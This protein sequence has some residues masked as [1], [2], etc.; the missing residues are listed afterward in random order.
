M[1]K[2]IV[3]ICPLNRIHSYGPDGSVRIIMEN[4][5]HGCVWGSSIEVGTHLFKVLDESGNIEFMADVMD[6]HSKGTAE[7]TST[8]G[9][10]YEYIYSPVN[11]LYV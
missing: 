11:N 1:K 7:R 9:R 5:Y 8:S 6:L 10:Y 2:V 3:A 4:G